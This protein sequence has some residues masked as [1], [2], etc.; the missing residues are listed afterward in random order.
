MHVNVQIGVGPL[1]A[2]YILQHWYTIWPMQG[3][4]LSSRS[5]R[6]KR[7]YYKQRPRCVRGKGTHDKQAPRNKWFEIVL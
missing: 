5:V 7:I 2:A 1:A 4:C 6:G 3:T